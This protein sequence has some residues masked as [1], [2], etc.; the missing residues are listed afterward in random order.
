MRRVG[1]LCAVL[2]AMTAATVAPASGAPVPASACVSSVGGLDLQRATLADMEGAMAA[3]RVSSA[4]LVK[5]YEARIAAYDTSGPKLNAIRALNPGAVAQARK[6]DA[7]RRAGH[8]RGPLH[9][10]P[11]LVKD[12]YGTTDQPTT[13]GSIALEGV[14]PKHDATVVQR[15]RDAGAVIL[16]KAN[17]SEFAGWVDLNMPP[18]YSSLAGQVINAH[19]PDFSPSGSSAGSGVAASMAFSG[20]TLGTETSGSIL[21]PSDANGDVGVKT[22]LGLVSRFGILPL[23]PDFDVPGPIVRSVTDAAI[24]L[25]AIAGP[26]PRDPATAD[27]A[28]H[29]PARGDYTAALRPGALRGARLAYSQDAHDSLDDEHRALF[30]A[31]IERLRKLGATVVAVNSFDSENVGLAEIAAVPNEFKASLNRYLAEQMPGAQVHSLSDIIAFN[32]QHPDR[33]K[34]GQGL[35]QASDAT[36]GREELFPVQ[37][38]PSR[39]SARE[40]ID[41]ALAE[42]QAD[43][44]I[45]PG[46]AHAN[47]GAAAGYPT[48]IEPL[49]YTNGGKD[50]FGIG[51]LGP[52]FSEPKLLGYAYAYEQD[53]HARVAPASVNPAVAAVPCSGRAVDGGV[54]TV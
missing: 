34:Y 9:G 1:A 30:D 13:A 6:L 47:V 49:G 53:A 22:T 20:A 39:T 12:N 41:G 14:V 40:S 35:L 27:A 19:D 8:V 17:L 50:P 11:I 5:A 18:G 31:G 24:V 38:E 43:A 46:N 48:V 4:K 21:S 26:D 33:V 52:A 3:G 45:T 23:A 28:S 32:N 15:L 10:I 2:A 44:I 51:F 7:E 54:N 42:G 16:G 37:A 25:G 36:P 29:L